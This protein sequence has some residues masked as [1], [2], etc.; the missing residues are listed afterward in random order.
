M[1]MNALLSHPLSITRVLICFST[2]LLGV[3]PNAFGHGGENEAQAAPTS[4][5]PLPVAERHL[6]TRVDID[7]NLRFRAAHAQHITKLQADQEDLVRGVF[8]RIRLG[9]RLRGEQIEAY[10]QFQTASVL[11]E[12][13]PIQFRDPG[14]DNAQAGDIPMPIGL[15][16]GR[17]RWR[18]PGLDGMEVEIGRMALDYG[19]GRQ[20]GSYD[21]HE[22]GNAFDGLRLGFSIKPYLTID[23][24]AV[25]LRRNTAHPETER[26]LFGAYIT[27]RP[28]ETL[29]SDLYLLYITDGAV[30]D[31]SELQTLGLR[32]AWQP[33]QWL[34][35]EGE[36]ALQVGTIQPKKFERPQD[37]L[38]TAAAAQLSSHTEFG[39]PM[40][41]TLQAQFYSGE[42]PESGDQHR[43]WR[44]LYPSLAKHLGLLQLFNQTNLLQ[45]G[46]AAQFGHDTGLRLIVDVRLNR[47]IAGTRVPGFGEP[48]LAGTAGRWEAIG[49]EVDTRLSWPIFERSE[50]LVASAL[51]AP[52]QALGDKNGRASAR[53]YLVQW[54]STF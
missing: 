47:S 30:D 11:G 25:K 41:L 17:L 26:N 1:S 44:P 46:G 33:V 53:L 23:T 20:I 48:T 10:I 31:R 16:Q 22:T 14:A 52:S 38:A 19:S 42:D 24:L 2:V 12:A 15:Q 27:A 3:Q 51:F 18:V 32:L 8:Q 4:P 35:V 29:V 28:T 49:M 34:D 45:Y 13:G 43:A 9:T 21:F 36:F 40:S 5:E 37:H 54:S 7:A 6:S 39:L 50:I